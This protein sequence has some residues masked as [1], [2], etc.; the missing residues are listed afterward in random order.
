MNVATD[1]QKT[2]VASLLA[3]REVG[4]E[5]AK[6][7]A[8]HFG[9]MTVAQA[10]KAIEYLLACPKVG[11]VKLLAEALKKLPKARFAVPVETAGL[12][13]R[14]EEVKDSMAFFAVAEYRGT[15][16]IRRLFGAPG[17]FVRRRMTVRDAIAIAQAIAESP[18]DYSRLFAKHH[19]VCGKC[20]AALTDDKSRAAGFGPDCRKQLGIK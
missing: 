7:L 6:W 17:E 1:K 8:L 13:L 16:Y 2:F 14:D 3:E 11:G 5:Q 9:D 15:L 19:S 4:V 18:L 12:V 20:A 10:S